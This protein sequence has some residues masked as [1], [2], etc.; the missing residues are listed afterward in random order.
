MMN[1]ALFVRQAEH[2]AERIRAAAADPR[3][4]IRLAYRVALA[5]SRAT[6]NASC[7]STTRRSTAWRTPAG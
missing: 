7:W 6:R 2:F 3:E 5:A 4:Q 1:N